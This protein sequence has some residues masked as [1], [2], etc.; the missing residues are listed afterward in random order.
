MR[1]FF[2]LKPF[3]DYWRA[4]PLMSSGVNDF[5]SRRFTPPVRTIL[6]AY[7]NMTTSAVEFW[8]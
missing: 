5:A 4:L 2:A 7:Q 6:H 8:K 3:V 1:L